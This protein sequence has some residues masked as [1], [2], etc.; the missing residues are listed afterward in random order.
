M[1]WTDPLRTRHHNGFAFTHALSGCDD[2]PHGNRAPGPEVD[3]LAVHSLRCAGGK[4]AG[5]RVGH[6]RQVPPRLQAS[7]PEFGSLPK[8]LEQDGRDD[9][10][11]RLP[12]AERVERAE[13]DH[14]NFV[15][16]SERF[17]QLV[18]CNLRGAVRRLPT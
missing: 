18:C 3:R 1:L 5:Y 2:I 17:T 6:E 11:G 16:A 8:E 12:W 4:E 10:P 7:Q 15:A 9:R 14:R 13:N